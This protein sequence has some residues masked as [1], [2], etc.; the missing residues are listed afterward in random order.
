[1]KRNNNHSVTNSNIP[2][3]YDR[4]R[5]G[6]ARSATRR[7]VVEFKCEAPQAEKVYVAGDFNHWRAGNDRLCRDEAGIWKTHLRLQPGRYQYRFIVDGEWQDDPHASTRVPNEFGSNNCVLDVQ[8]SA[9]EHQPV[10]CALPE[11]RLA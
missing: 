9:A 5:N 3:R 6:D 10:N 8:P 1:M 7:V 11:G 2:A 4:H